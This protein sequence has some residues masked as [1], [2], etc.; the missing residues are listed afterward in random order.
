[1]L[2]VFWDDDNGS[3]EARIAAPETDIG[4]ASEAGLRLVDRSVSRQHAVILQQDDKWILRDRASQNGIRIGRS[5]ATEHEIHDGDVA[6]LGQ[7]RLRFVV[8]VHDSIRLQNDESRTRYQTDAAVPSG[9]IIIDATEAANLPLP[10]AP[11]EKTSQEPSPP[12]ALQGLMTVAQELLQADHIEHLFSRILDLVFTYVPV[13]N[14][15]L[16]LH[17]ADIDQLVPKATRSRVGTLSGEPI[18][19]RIVL[20]TFRTREAV[21]TPDMDTDTRFT[22]GSIDQHGIRSALSVPLCTG[23][24]ALGVIFADSTTQRAPLEARH[25]HFLA[26]LAHL[27][28]TA[29]EQARLRDRINEESVLRE[30]LMRYQSPTL[31]EEL[32]TRPGAE[33]MMEPVERDA[34]VLFADLVGFSTR[35]ESMPPRDVA[36]MLN[37]MLSEMVDIVFKHGGTL[38]KFI[39]DAVMALF[40]VPNEHTDHAMQAVQCAMDMQARLDELDAE[41]PDPKPLQLRIGINSGPVVAGDI[42]SERRME[43]TVLGNTVNIAARLE[44]FAARPG[45]IVI[46]PATQEAVSDRVRTQ[47]LGEQML[48]GMSQPVAAY[49]VTR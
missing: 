5:Y 26:L 39:G 15:F 14:A 16:I 43:Y 29:I 32:M 22:G 23:D 9:S 25:L 30:R 1:M 35:T 11:A 45:E 46:G 17:E 8:S 4:R 31:V 7:V 10:S 24:T 40:G 48:K 18:S 37:R 3:H 2:Y 44:A 47:P 42:G 33:T 36:R 6:Y 38:D 28:A 19:R 41:Q 34:S 21:L 27:A 13:E 12:D 49:V 20:H